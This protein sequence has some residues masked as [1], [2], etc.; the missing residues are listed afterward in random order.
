MAKAKRA[1]LVDADTLVYSACTSSE[2]EVEWTPG[3]W[4][5]HCDE[6]EAWEH[7]EAELR[8]IVKRMHADK[9]VMALSDY[10]NERFRNT[11]FPSYKSNRSGGRKPLAFMAIRARIEA[12]YETWIKPTLEGDDILGILATDDR[13]LP[14]W[15]KIIVSLD[16]DMKTIPGW[17][18]DYNKSTRSQDWKPIKVTES[19]AFRFFLTQVLTGD[20]VD[21]YKGCPGVGPVGAAKVIDAV[22]EDADIWAAIVEVY[23][24][25]GLSELE[26][27]ENAR[28][29]RILH[30]C[31]YDFDRREP[32][33]WTP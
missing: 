8:G 33:A 15:Q 20:T 9:V 16:K 1:L 19:D 23:E 6:N 4:T 17:L 31:D 7:F 2:Q 12:E 32:I 18:I 14:G 5:L 26:A 28:M 24:S 3:F 27:L 11:W 25:K 22:T 30:A 10:E 13:Y 29:A 21:G